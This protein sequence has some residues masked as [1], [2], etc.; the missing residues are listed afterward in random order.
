MRWTTWVKAMVSALWVVGLAACGGDSGV[1]WLSIGGTVQGLKGSVV[2]A[3][4]RTSD[5]DLLTRDASGAF[6]FAGK[7]VEYGRYTVTVQTQPEGQV[8][9]V[10]NGSGVFTP[11]DVT[12]IEVTCVDAGWQLAHFMG[13]PTGVAGGFDVPATKATALLTEPYFVQY[14]SIEKALWVADRDA[15][16]AG[17]VAG[18]QSQIFEVGMNASSQ[19]FPY[20][21]HKDKDMAILALP[22]KSGTYLY[23]QKGS[24]QSND[25]EKTTLYAAVVLNAPRGMVQDS[26]GNVYVSDVGDHVIRKLKTNGQ[27]EVF[28]GSVGN[29]GFDSGKGNAARFNK[30]WGLAIDRSGNLYVADKLNNAIRKVTPDGTVTTLAGDGTFGSTDG[31][32]SGA[33]FGYPEGVAVDPSGNVYVADTSNN[34]IRKITSAGVVSTVA[35][36]AG[37]DGAGLLNGKGLESKLNAPTSLTLDTDGNIYIADR[38]SNT[39]RKMF[40]AAYTN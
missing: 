32:G 33:R 34:L 40:Y 24:I 13:S 10:S 20:T 12:N 36:Q 27:V 35:G 22:D 15:V 21:S 37:N 29:S 31:T 19:L 3:L 6:T 1:K 39:I 25:P 28:A 7:I 18:A 2:L 23:T 26:A 5:V 4:D 14:S 17:E 16:N 8:C 9:S 30:P 11:Y 38:G